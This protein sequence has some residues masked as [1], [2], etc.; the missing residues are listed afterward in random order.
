[1]TMTEQTIIFNFQKAKQQA[2]ELEQ[3]ANDLSN[4]SGKDFNSIMQNVSTSWKGE[5][6]TAY[7][8]KGEILQEDMVKT[9]NSLRDV[10]AEIRKTAKRLYDAE[11]EA[12]RIAKE[13][14]Y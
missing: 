8:K 12:L 2:D 6:A 3:I 11:M 1:M 5:A 9:A 7:L 10:A 14:T 13:R 4:L